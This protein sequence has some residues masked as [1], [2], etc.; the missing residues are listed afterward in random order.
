MCF[1][2]S[3]C[4]LMVRFCYCHLTFHCGR[5]LSLCKKGISNEYK[6]TG[7]EQAC[8]ENKASAKGLENDRVENRD[9]SFLANP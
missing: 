6:H 1:L 9:I 8:Q 3:D 7:G 4:H 2:G 5:R